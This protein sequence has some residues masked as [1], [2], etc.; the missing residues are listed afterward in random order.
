MFTVLSILIQRNSL[1]NLSTVYV[2][3]NTNYKIFM[4][5]KFLMTNKYNII[6]VQIV[7]KG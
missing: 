6:K 5:I 1:Y 3:S 2:N 4:Y 7:Q